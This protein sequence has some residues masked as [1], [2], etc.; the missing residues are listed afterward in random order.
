MPISYYLLAAVPAAWLLPNHSYP[1]ISAWLEGLALGLL[2]LGGTLVRS[3]GRLPLAWAAALA[4]AL[5]SVALQWGT[6]LILYSGDALMT[7][8]YLGAFGVS[9][10]LGSALAAPE[11]DGRTP[12]LEWLAMGTVAAAI[13]TVGIALSQ[14][15][16]TYVIH[17]TVSVDLKPGARPY[18]NLAQANHFCTATFLGLCSLALLHETKRVGR[19]GFWLGTSFLLMGMVMSGSRTGWLQFLVLAAMVLL[20]QRRAGLRIRAPQVI[21]LA[22][23]YAA[24]TFAW[25]ALNDA[26]LLGGGRGVAQQLGG[27]VRLPLWRSLLD[28]VSQQPLTGYGW[29]QAGIAQQAVALDHPAVKHLFEHSHN[30]VLDLIL[31][32][33]VPTG[34]A[35]VVLTAAALRWQLASLLDARAF[36]MMIGAMGVLTH[37]MLEY[38]IEYA[39]FL[40][41][42]GLALGAA[43]ALCP[44]QRALEL[45]AT[46]LRG[47]SLALGLVTAVVAVDYLEAEQNQMLLRLESARIGVKGIESKEPELVLLDQLQAFLWF[48]RTEPRAGMTP[49]ELVQTQQVAQRFAYMPILLKQAQIAGLHGDIKGAERS[50]ALVCSLHSPARCQEAREDWHQLQLRYPQVRTV[51]VP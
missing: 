19:S 26:L 6:G 13:F 40:L 49:A 32:V 22:L 35:I 29:Q 45:K 28:A 47:A 16:Q 14:W 8:L 5:L 23:L 31:W 21:G 51:R 3:G 50:L 38:P 25:P 9:I 46:A 30:L 1:W 24:L 10:A 34:A 43:H 17:F 27:G 12:A 11:Q 18:G 15:T 7:A 48:A 33:G 42:L 4:L 44:G 36:W 37:S 20:L 2:L 41:P 39:Y